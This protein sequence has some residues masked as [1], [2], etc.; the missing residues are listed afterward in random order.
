MCYVVIAYN[1]LLSKVKTVLSENFLS[2]HIYYVYFLIV[3]LIY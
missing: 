2:A 3:G 1:M